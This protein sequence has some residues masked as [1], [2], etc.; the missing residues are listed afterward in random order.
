LALELETLR[1]LVVD[2][3]PVHRCRLFAGGALD[4]HGDVS[5][6]YRKLPT[7]AMSEMMAVIGTWPV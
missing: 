6:P 4:R 2:R 7:T 1:V 3:H 5:Y